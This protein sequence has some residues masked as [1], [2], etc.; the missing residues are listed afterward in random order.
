MVEVVH[1]DEELFL[2]LVV[3][4]EAIVNWLLNRRV[5]IRRGNF[6][7]RL[8]CDLEEKLV[9]IITVQDFQDLKALEEDIR[10]EVIAS[11]LSNRHDILS[12]SLGLAD[13]AGGSSRVG[14]VGGGDFVR[15][16]IHAVAQGALAIVNLSV[17]RLFV[18]KDTVRRSGYLLSEARKAFR[19][20]T[21]DLGV[22]K[23][24]VKRGDVLRSGIYVSLSL[25]LHDLAMSDL[26]LLLGSLGLLKR[27]LLGSLL[28]LEG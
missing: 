5:W 9:L 4:S 24:C 19:H 2:D 28:L 6:F 14:S 22:I 11:L 8:G 15:I 10:L 20:L 12:G 26:Q 16:V 21:V 1:H 23:S 18:L 13:G 17:I 27:G 3:D 25:S 7:E